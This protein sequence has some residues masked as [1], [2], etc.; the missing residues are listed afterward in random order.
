MDYN[1]TD[2]KA[3]RGIFVSTVRMFL[4]RELK[5]RYVSSL[6]GPL[7]IILYPVSFTLIT[8]AVFSLVFHGSVNGM[9]YVLYVLLGF[10]MWNFFQQS[11][12][13]STRVLLWNRDIVAN[14][15]FSKITLIISTILGRG[16]DMLINFG[17]F[18]VIASVYMHEILRVQFIPLF[19]VLIIQTLLILGIS[20]ITAILNVYFRDI[21]NIT[22]ISLQLLFYASPIIYPVTILPQPLRAVIVWNPLTMILSLYRDAAWGIGLHIQDM[23]LPA[24]IA[25][26]IALFGYG[27]F[28]TYEST[29][30]DII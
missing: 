4:Q 1:T 17:V 15:R 8:T 28:K 30:S 13:Q 11:I 10:I 7:W 25:C 29:I 3:T 19:F 2:M 5:T 24:G 23:A 27:I 12:A 6:L 26:G 22:D 18:V 20:C 14:H 21:E 9:P 16:I